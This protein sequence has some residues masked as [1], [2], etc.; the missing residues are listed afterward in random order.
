MNPSEQ[1]A[2]RW[3]GEV[4]N[5]RNLPLISE[6]MA[7]DAVGHLEGPTSKIVGVDEFIA[8][9]EGLLAAL[10]DI[11]VAIL[12]SLS[13]ES[14]ACVMWQAQAL[15]GA[16]SFRGTTWFRV[17]DGKIV[18]GWDCWDHGALVAR[19]AQLSAKA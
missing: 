10:P 7:A 1:I 12:K 19:L 6:L 16:V 15:G 14:E 3:F 13:S 18:E 11:Q 8:F 9:Q 2:H 5:Q 4:W 17:V